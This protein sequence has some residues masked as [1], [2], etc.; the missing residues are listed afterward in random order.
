MLPANQV[1]LAKRASINALRTNPSIVPSCA[2]RATPTAACPGNLSDLVPESVGIAM[3]IVE[4]VALHP[5]IG[6]ICVLDVER[7]VPVPRRE[8]GK[9][10]PCGQ[11]R[12]AE[13]LPANPCRRH[14]A[15]PGRDRST[16]GS[17]RS[18]ALGECQADGA[19]RAADRGAHPA[20]AHAAMQY[21]APGP[22]AR[23][24]SSCSPQVDFVGCQRDTDPADESCSQ[25]K[26]K[27]EIV[28]DMRARRCL[29]E[30][31]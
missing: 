16:P 26:P 23:G 30:D 18:P 21:Q 9:V 13:A 22:Y 6:T 27:S 24:R 29:Q 5:Q 8:F 28:A 2:Q 25:S 20:N 4:R 17:R 3:S 7:G 14:R 31:V 12:Q 19:E 1:P 10:A 15:D 11:F